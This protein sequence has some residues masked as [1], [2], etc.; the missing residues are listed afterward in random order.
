MPNANQRA[1]ASVFVPGMSINKTDEFFT[2]VGLIA[3]ARLKLCEN[4]LKPHVADLLEIQLRK[5]RTEHCSE[6][7]LRKS[8][9]GDML[10]SRNSLQ[11]LHSRS[12]IS[13]DGAG[14][15]RAYNHQI[16]ANQ[17]CLAV[18]GL[19]IKNL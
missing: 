6:V 13:L 18:L 15:A 11:H 16:R 10:F 17:H 8:Y 2:S 4:C 7:R 5:N 3:P 1:G 19:E 14:S 12:A 9:S